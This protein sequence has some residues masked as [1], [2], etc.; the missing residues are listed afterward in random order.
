MK[1]DFFL[2]ITD[3]TWGVFSY[4]I[5]PIK[6]MNDIPTYHNLVTIVRIIVRMKDLESS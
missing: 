6:L 2:D 4:E 3:N 1:H 5:L